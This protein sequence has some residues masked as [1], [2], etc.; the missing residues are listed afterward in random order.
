MMTHWTS[1]PWHVD[2]FDIFAG[3]TPCEAQ[4]IATMSQPYGPRGILRVQADACL[5]VTRRKV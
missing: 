1:R 3:I 4:H 5:K 2:R